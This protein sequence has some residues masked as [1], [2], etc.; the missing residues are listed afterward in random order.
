MGVCLPPL[1]QS[2]TLPYTSAKTRAS[3]N[4]ASREHDYEPG[5]VPKTPAVRQ[6]HA[7]RWGKPHPR[8]Q[9]QPG[10]TARHVIGQSAGDCKTL[11][12]KFRNNIILLV[13]AKADVTEAFRNGRVSPDHA[14]KFCYAVDHVLVA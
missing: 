1:F 7:C 9:K 10:I 6:P 14:H 3:L 2:R 12:V 4:I 13:I 5:D 11:R 8:R